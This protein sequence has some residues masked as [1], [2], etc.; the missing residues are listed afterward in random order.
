MAA[1]LTLTGHDVTHV[2]ETLIARDATAEEELVF[3]S[4]RHRAFCDF[5]TCSE[6]VLLKR[7]TDRIKRDA[8]MHHRDGCSHET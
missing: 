8:A 6:G 1:S 7:P 2:T 4:M 5:N 3:S